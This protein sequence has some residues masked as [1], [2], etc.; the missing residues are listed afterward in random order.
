MWNN[1]FTEENVWKLNRPK[2][3]LLHVYIIVVQ[4]YLDICYLSANI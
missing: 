2:V 3:R 4:I 1:L